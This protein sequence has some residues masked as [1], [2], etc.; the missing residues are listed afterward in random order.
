M[1]KSTDNLSSRYTYQLQARCDSAAWLRV[2]QS[3]VEYTHTYNLP[4]CYSFGNISPVIN[5]QGNI[6]FKVNDQGGVDFGQ[7]LLRLMAW[8][9]IMP[10]TPQPPH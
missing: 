9:F 3:A 10:L 2:R 8:L 5:N 6:A 7:S 1:F 4:D